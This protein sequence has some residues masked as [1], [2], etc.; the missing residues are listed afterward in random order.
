MLSRRLPL[1]SRHLSARS[2]SFQKQV[3]CQD[4]DERRFNASVPAVS[5]HVCGP[6]AKPRPLFVS[7]AAPQKVCDDS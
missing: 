1:A 2:I 5:D 7:P 6:G 4:L 3:V